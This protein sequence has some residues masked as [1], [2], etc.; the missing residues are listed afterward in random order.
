MDDG[1]GVLEL[2]SVLN[3][4]ADKLDVSAGFE[5]VLLT[6][7]LAGELSCRRCC[8]GNSWVIVTG[9]PSALRLA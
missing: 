3:D 5:D 9:R 2:L 8:V 1:V 6:R 7:D 4:R